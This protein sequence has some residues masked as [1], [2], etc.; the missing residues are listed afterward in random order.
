VALGPLRRPVWD[1]VETARPATSA[2]DVDPGILAR[3]KPFRDF[4]R[5][6]GNERELSRAQKDFRKGYRRSKAS[7]V[8]RKKPG[9][10]NNANSGLIPFFWADFWDAITLFVAGCPRD[11]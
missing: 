11:G 8:A 4:P 10:A 9:E 7:G 6:S 5:L 3:R 2:V 1:S